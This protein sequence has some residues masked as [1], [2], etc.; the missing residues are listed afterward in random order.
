M[1]KN[2]PQ[3][4]QSEEVD[5]GQL[6]KLIGNMF[7][8]FFKF[9]GMIFG[10]VFQLLMGVILFFHKHFLKFAIAG[11]LGL[12]LGFYLEK[13]KP[14]LYYSRMVVEPNFESSKQLHN[15]I[16]FYNELVK[17]NDSISLANALNISTSEASKLQGFSIKSFS[18]KNELRLRYN[19]FLKQLDSAA[20]VDFTFTTYSKN[21]IGINSR[22]HSIICE[23]L[24]NLVPKKVEQ[25]IIGAISKNE[26]FNLQMEINEKN[27]DLQD[28]IYKKQL[29]ELD[30]LHLLY[31]KVMIV[32][33]NN[34][35]KGTNIN[36]A[37]EKQGINSEL[38]LI[39]L[40]YELKDKL[41][42]LNK[43][44]ARTNKIINVISAFPTKSIELYE[45]YYSLKFIIPAFLILVVFLVLVLIEIN[46]YLKNYKPKTETK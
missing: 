9:I 21:F 42:L 1:S 28:N 17:D 15:N 5:L 43:E 12:L 38:D 18:S 11:V 41:V 6:F 22:Y 4:Q 31:K 2:L 27:I 7:D 33:A 26:Y 32:S 39:E 24:D 10:M 13:E 20:Q 23:T 3:P 16:Y 46:K 34:P 44:R 14:Q 29:K 19:E 25:A 45:P 35:N 30:S 8:R 40:R 36:L 37:D